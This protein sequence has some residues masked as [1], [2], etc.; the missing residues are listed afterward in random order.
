[1]KL[2]DRNFPVKSRYVSV[3]SL[4]SQLQQRFC[5]LDF[6]FVSS[7]PFCGAVF[8]V[9]NTEIAQFKTPSLG[10]FGLGSFGGSVVYSARGWAQQ[11]LMLFELFK[12]TGDL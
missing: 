11:T 7:G 2:I 8:L 3:G 12:R 5:R 9:L 1:M 10:L 6:G 4:P